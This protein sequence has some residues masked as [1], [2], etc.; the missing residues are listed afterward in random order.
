MNHD[1]NDSE[2]LVKVFARK[3]DKKTKSLKLP[4]S[5]EGQELKSII[6]FKLNIPFDDLI[7][8]AKGE[9]IKEEVSLESKTI[10]HAID[11]RKVNQ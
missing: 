8:Y 11:A 5:I 2:E 10:I 7:L 3:V 9:L 4:Q 1:S 6:S